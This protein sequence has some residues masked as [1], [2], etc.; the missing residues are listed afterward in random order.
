MTIKEIAEAI[1]GKPAAGLDLNRPIYAIAALSAADA[2]SISWIDSEKWLKIAES[3]RAAALIGSGALV[4]KL[5]NGII[6]SDTQTSV[7]D[8]L[9]LFAPKDEIVSGIHPTAVVENGAT[10]AS[11]A[12]IGPQAVIR[13]GSQIGERTVVG[14]GTCIGRG[15]SIGDDC[16][17]HDRVVIYDR[18]AV[19]NRVILHAGAVIGAD[20]FGYIFRN[21]HH[22][23]LRHIGTV[24][25][26]DDVEIGANAAVDRAKV[27][28][29]RIGRGSKIDNLV[30][31]AHNVVLGPLCILAGQVGL[32]G[33]VRL[34]TG[35]VMAGQVGVADGLE[36]ADGTQV[37][38]RSGVMSS[39]PEPNTTVYGDPATD[40]QLMKRVRLRLKKLPQL[41]D[42]VASLEKKV[43]NRD[44]ATDH[45]ETG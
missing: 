17:L 22:R 5:P 10:V 2:S 43:A 31:V 4:G 12:S 20:G 36:L 26:E 15:V 18:C 30:Q 1:G 44:G 14:A 38:A 32:S 13:T 16:R 3:S 25:I 45:R 8:L 28:E 24:V 27:G 23:K 35:C 41:F 29:T 37:G 19:G 7:A 42:R 39:I 11:T 34:G 21:G 33:S 6:V 40:H 9:E